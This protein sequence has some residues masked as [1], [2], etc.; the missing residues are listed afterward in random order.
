MRFLSS[1]HKMTIA[2]YKIGYSQSRLNLISEDN[3]N[4]KNLT[5]LVV[6]FNFLEA[7]G[8]VLFVFSNGAN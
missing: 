5:K 1:N 6:R 8:E 4:K 3:P 7:K 2:F